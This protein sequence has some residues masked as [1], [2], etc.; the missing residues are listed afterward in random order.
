VSTDRSRATN[1]D[2]ANVELGQAP[3]GYRSGFVSIIGRPNVGKSTLLNQILQTKVAITSSRP[4]TTRNLIRGILTTPQ[5]QLVFVDTPGMHKPRSALG[6]RL[7]KVVRNTIE[8]VDTVLFVVDTAAGVGDGDMFIANEL[9]RARVPV[10]AVL[11]KIDAADPRSIQD[12]S[13][14]ILE[15]TGWPLHGTSARTGAGVP[16]LVGEIVQGLPEGPLYY[17]PDSVTDQSQRR[18]IAELIREKV[19]ERT[20]QEVPHS[21][22]VIV[23]DMFTEDDGT[24]RIDATIFVERDSQKGIVIGKGG[25]LLKEI[26]TSARKEI[27]ALVGSHVFLGLRVKVEHDWQSDD[28]RIAK[29]G[30]GE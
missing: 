9:K 12:G 7:N 4:Q 14:L 22:A 26:G 24:I 20:H 13:R 15:T 25:G 23:E 21:V 5:A 29:F 16:E 11:N 27:E 17:P 1:G 6:R 10:L 19:L 18:T 8:E 30:Y 28:S 2:I 3:S